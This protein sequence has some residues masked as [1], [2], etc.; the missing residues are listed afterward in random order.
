MRRTT[1]LALAALLVSIALAY[2]RAATPDS[3]T[4]DWDV[5]FELQ[6][7]KTPASFHF[8]LDGENVKGTAY[9]HH[10]GP[11]TIRAGSWKDGK[12]SF[13]LDFEKHESIDVTGAL[14][15]EK[16]AGEFRTE[17]RQGR[18][19]AQRTAPAAK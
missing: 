17:G 5:S 3:L 1:L 9:S 7:M 19:T 11:G 13:T 16:L 18:W 14:D 15:G 4:G 6:G 12:L 10:T 2:S 8:E